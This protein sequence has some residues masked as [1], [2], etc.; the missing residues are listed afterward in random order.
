M[1]RIGMVEDSEE[2]LDDYI[3]RMRREELELLIAPE[4]NMEWR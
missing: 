3:K 4:G 1:Y 2:L